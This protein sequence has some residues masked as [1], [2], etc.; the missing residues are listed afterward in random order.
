ML[1][2]FT[3][4]L[5]MILAQAQTAA[6]EKPRPSPECWRL[7]ANAVPGV[8]AFCQAQEAMRAAGTAAE[9]ELKQRRLRTAAELFNRAANE[10]RD[11]DVKIVALESLAE[12]ND[13]AHLNDPAGLEQALRALV[14][15]TPHDS[16]P[17]RR[18]AKL[19]EDQGYLDTAEQTLLSARQQL[20]D[21]PA[22]YVELSAFYGRRAAAIEKTRGKTAQDGS[23][24][25]GPPQPESDGYYRVGDSI[26]APEP[27]DQSVPA[28]YPFEAQAKGIEGDVMVELKIDERGL[29]TDARIVTS[30]PGLDEEALKTARRWRF[31]PTLI[32]GR[33]VPTKMILGVS[34]RIEK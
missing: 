28:Q 6:E 1:I 34:F 13:P 21:D 4:A 8:G 11:P 18:I 17:L 9:P 29:V 14:P 7:P 12:V 15:L 25:A 26:P 3:L 23:E 32:D 30:V 20:P 5:S 10:L 27:I 22:V 31:A 2:G 16:S 33:A 19:Q 24:P